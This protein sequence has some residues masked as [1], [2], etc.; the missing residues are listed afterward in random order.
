MSTREMTLPRR[1]A[2]TAIVAA[3]VGGWVWH[4]VDVGR[5]ASGGAFAQA[6]VTALTTAPRGFWSRP[7]AEYRFRVGGTAYTG[8]VPVATRA[9][10]GMRTGQPLEIR[11]DR[12]NP[13]RHIVIPYGLADVHDWKKYAIVLGVAAILLA[14][15]WSGYRRGAG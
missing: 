12:A 11:Y 10:E 7:G 14:W 5:L 4:L 8:S 13:E 15:A 9:W 6:A 3:I 1:I 2:I